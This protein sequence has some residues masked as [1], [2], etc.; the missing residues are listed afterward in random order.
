MPM[1][2]GAADMSR[3]QAGGI[4]TGFVFGEKVLLL[5]QI[6]IHIA[7]Y[8]GGHGP[9]RGTASG[10]EHDDHKLARTGFVEG[11]EPSEVG[12]ARGTL[13]AG[14]GLAHDGVVLLGTLGGAKVDSA[15]QARL[16]QI[17]IRLDIEV[18]LDLGDEALHGILVFGVLKPV[19]GSTVG[20][21]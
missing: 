1:L 4:E 14:A 16:N 20:D 6:A 21:G 17:D 2:L 19:E 8:A 7:G 10:Q 13:A 9:D 12:F 5:S 3:D 15:F 11:S 18:A